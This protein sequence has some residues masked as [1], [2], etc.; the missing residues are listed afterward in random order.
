MK[1][2]LFIGILV[3]LLAAGY[4]TYER[5]QNPKEE[6]ASKDLFDLPNMAKD[7]MEKFKGTLEEKYEE[8]ESI[9]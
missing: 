1:G 4:M 8:A 6:G 7:K 5:M 2:I 9:D 3:A